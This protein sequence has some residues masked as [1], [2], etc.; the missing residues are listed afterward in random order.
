MATIPYIAGAAVLPA[1][2][3]AEDMQAAGWFDPPGT[4]T[5]RTAT[6]RAAVLAAGGTYEERDLAALN[7]LDAALTAAGLWAKVSGLWPLAGSDLLAA[8][9]PYGPGGSLTASG[10]LGSDFTRAGGIT[11]RAGAALKS[12]IV[13]PGAGALVA[14]LLTFPAPGLGG[15]PMSAS[16][17]QG[18]QDY[19]GNRLAGYYET[20]NT[21]LRPTTQP[22][23]LAGVW[24]ISRNAGPSPYLN[25]LRKDGAVQA[26][27]S[28]TNILAGSTGPVYLMARNLSNAIATPWVGG[29]GSAFAV[30]AG[31]VTQAEHAA[32]AQALAAMRSTLGR[33]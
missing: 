13:A 32:L 10:F 3:T 4:A 15:W 20:S 30:L 17:Y 31:T 12:S 28:P 26:S 8:C 24:A 9:V 1:P 23:P 29:R 11:G 16:G 18:F 6:W 25:E 14:D 7:A 19:T 22:A 21:A 5:E 2:K 33:A 27:R